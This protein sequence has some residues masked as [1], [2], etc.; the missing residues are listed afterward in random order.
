MALVAEGISTGQPN[1]DKKKAQERKMK[2]EREAW[3]GVFEGDKI[4]PTLEQIELKKKREVEAAEKEAR[5]YEK[6]HRGGFNKTKKG[7]AGVRQK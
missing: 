5:K 3:Y 4:K 2:F 1:Y 7:K 6:S